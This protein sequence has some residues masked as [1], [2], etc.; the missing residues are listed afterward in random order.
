[1]DSTLKQALTQY[2]EIKDAKEELNKQL[3]ELNAQESYTQDLIIQSM[4]SEG[5]DKVSCPAGTASIKTDIYP[6]IKDMPS[7]MRW[8][9]GHGQYHVLRADS[10]KAVP[11]RELVLGGEEVDGVEEFEKT[12]LSFRR[13]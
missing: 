9:V 12:K 4:Q 10:L 6:S 1:M 5:L 8:V 11:Y 13:K 2:R 3:K 7:F